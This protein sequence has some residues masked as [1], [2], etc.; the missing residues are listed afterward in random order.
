MAIP[1]HPLR[2]WIDTTPVL[3]EGADLTESLEY[4][5]EPLAEPHRDPDML[6]TLGGTCVHFGERE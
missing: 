1:V 2:V 6:T 5:S 3:V 4:R